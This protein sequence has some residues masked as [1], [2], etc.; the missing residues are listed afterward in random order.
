MIRRFLPIVLLALFTACGGGQNPTTPQAPPA[1]PPALPKAL[2]GAFV[3]TSDAVPTPLYYGAPESDSVPAPMPVILFA[4]ECTTRAYLGGGRGFAGAVQINPDNSLNVSPDYHVNADGTRSALTLTGTYNAAAENITGTANGV[5]F[6]AQV[7]PDP[8]LG[9]TEPPSLET[10]LGAYRSQV[11]GAYGLWWDVTL[12]KLPPSPASPKPAYDLQGVIYDSKADMD[13]KR[14]GRFRMS[15]NVSNNR[16]R[17]WGAWSISCAFDRL[18]DDSLP[19]DPGKGI[20]KSVFGLCNWLPTGELVFVMT[21]HN[22]NFHYMGIV[23][24]VP[25][26]P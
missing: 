6:T 17:W 11:P 26:A 10:R 23:A 22:A 16:E 20:T 1:P 24:P 2:S 5:S 7:M 8:K 25:V 14:N 4:Q 13:A 12:V 3:G 19:G 18:R 9:G 21:S 15:A